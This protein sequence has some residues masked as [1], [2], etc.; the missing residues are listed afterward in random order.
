MDREPSRVPRAAADGGTTRTQEARPSGAGPPDRNAAPRVLLVDDEPGF[1]SPLAK[2]LERRGMRVVEAGTGEEA[3]D[4]LAAAPA[5]VVV[6]D[7]MMPGMGGLAALARIRADHPAVQVI[8]LTG[9]AAVE[10]GVQGIQEGA[11]DYLR[12]P[13][14]LEHLAGKIRQ[15]WERKV[16]E[17]ERA[18]EARFREE[19]EIR[20]VTA[21]RLAALGTLAAGVAHEINNPLAIISEASGLMRLVLAKE[22]ALP[23]DFARKVENALSKVEKSVLRAKRIT[24]Q[25]LGFARTPEPLMRDVSLTGLC[26]E[27]VVLLQSESVRAGVFLERAETGEDVRVWTDPQG[28]RQ[29]LVNLM[30]NALA[31]SGPGQKVV[32][33]AEREDR[34]A[35]I[36]VADSGVGIPPENLTRIFEPFFTT[37][38]AS[39]GTGLGLFVSANIL[40][41]LGGRID[42]ESRVGKGSVFFV[43]LPEKCSARPVQGPGADWLET[44]RNLERS[45]EN[46]A[47]A[48]QRAR[49]G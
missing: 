30:L 9:H 20:M 43:H 4:A 24:H 42:V 5:D 6:M 22:K 29:V 14:E 16:R 49:G 31:A 26:D 17:T 23:E 33:R 47:G 19:M 1:R 15:A 11:F 45:G 41:G 35:V 38:S 37:K 46:G 8:L 3:L 32:A 21:E 25:L 2:R 40:K 39:S 12:K 36:S 44:A 48:D 7:V 18:A 13:V 10:D 27:V 28:L 34:G